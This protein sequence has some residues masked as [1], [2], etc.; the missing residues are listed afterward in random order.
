VAVSEPGAVATGQRFNLSAVARD[1]ELSIEPVATAP[2]SDKGEA[3]FVQSVFQQQKLLVLSLSLMLALAAGGFAQ[4][5]GTRSISF[6][7]SIQWTKQK[8]VA[9]YRLQIASDENFR[10][11]FF[12]GRVSG[13]RYTVTGLPPGYYFWRTA[14]SD[15]YTGQF[16]NP[17]RF[18]VSGGAVVSPAQPDKAGRRPRARTA[19]SNIH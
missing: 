12:D 5:A 18:F 16:S 13:A 6:P 19:V 7:T 2:G 3:L 4:Q 9:K 17:A 14:P 11:I 1:R 10:N 8:G 15:F